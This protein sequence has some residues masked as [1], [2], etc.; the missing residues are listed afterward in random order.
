MPGGDDRAHRLGDLVRQRGA[1]GVAQRHVLRAGLVG[2]AHAAQRVVAVAAPGVEEVLGVVDRP[3]CPPP[4]RKATESAIIRRFS[5]GSTRTTF[6]RC[7]DHVLPTSVQTGAKQEASSRS[8]GSS[9]ARDVAP[10]RHPERAHVGARSARPR[11]ARRAP[12]PSGSRP[13]S[14][15]RSKRDAEVVEQVR[16]AHLLLGRERHPLPLHP[17]AQGGVVDQDRGSRGGCRRGHHVQPVGVALR[18]AV[19]RVLEDVL[20]LARDRA[21]AGPRRRAGR[22]SRAAASAR[23]RCRS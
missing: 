4:T 3:A 13:G 14:R 5:S 23:R 21:R 10:A 6:S 16:D 20:D 7:S 12:P 11:G 15:P 8:A 2:G 9:S 22:R 1:V 17:V 18:A 19:Q